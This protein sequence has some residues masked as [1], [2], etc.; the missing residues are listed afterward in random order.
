MRVAPHRFA[1][2]LSV[3]FL[4]F[5]AGCSSDS[6]GDVDASIALEADALRVIDSPAA[7][8]SAEPRLTVGADDR[9]YLSWIESG[10]EFGHAL[11]FATWESDGWSE[12]RTI[13]TGTDWFV[14]WADFP[15][16]AAL[17][18][19]TLAAHWLVKSADSTYA[20]DVVLS[21]SNDAGAHWSDPVS[22]HD[23]GTPTEHGFVSLVPASDD[24]FDVI[25]LDGRQ[26]A[27]DPPG[28]MTLRHARLNAE[29]QVTPATLIDSRV[30][31]C[32][33]TEARRASD[34][35]VVVAYRGRTEEE[36]RDI[37]ISRYNGETWTPPVSVHED[38]WVVAGCPVNGPAIEAKGETVAVAWY[39][40]PSKGQGA[41]RLAFSSDDGATFDAPLSMDQGRP[42]GRVDLALLDDG[43]AL[44][45]W[46]EQGDDGAA[47]LVRRADR[48]GQIE[49]ARVAT[50][51]SVSRSSGFPQMLRFEGQTFIAW[52]EISEDGTQVRTGTLV[53]D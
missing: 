15:S 53:P 48:Y 34:G 31:D 43:S 41:V 45:S 21:T 6:S 46:L 4:A 30:C 7:P 52:T 1:V 28:P 13:A 9:L 16:L 33:P 10:D 40:E 22:P 2:V 42:L 14:N 50:T 25:W 39:T 44:V 37:R 36:V 23:D 11:Q 27:D 32:C 49:P 12:P 3:L 29:G 38:G 19:G 18:D 47:I 51:T 35:N 5:V 8:H 24:S 26:A 20:Y 17:P